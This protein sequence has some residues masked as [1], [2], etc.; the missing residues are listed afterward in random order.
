MSQEKVDKYKQEKK[1]RKNP[2][3]TSR[4]KKAIPYV[5]T[6]IVVI[7]ILGYLGI[8]VAKQSG[9]YTTPTEPKSWNQQEIESLRQVLIQATDPNVK[10]TTAKQEQA[11]AAGQKIQSNN[12]VDVKTNQKTKVKTT[13]KSAKK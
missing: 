12:K 1:N 11:S 7:L 4:V 5:I 10:Y 3:K 6:G 2:K 8:S 9:L 13:K